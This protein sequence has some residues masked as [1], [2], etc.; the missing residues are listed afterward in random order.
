MASTVACKCHEQPSLAGKEIALLEDAG[1]MEDMRVVPLGLI[2]EA[3]SLV[4]HHQQSTVIEHIKVSNCLVRPVVGE[5][6]MGCDVP[7]STLEL[8]LL[9]DIWSLCAPNAADDIAGFG[10]DLVGI[11]QQLQSS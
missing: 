5:Q 7:M 8:Q 9:Q 6:V 1:A 4:L 10:N 2:L 11:K 3:A